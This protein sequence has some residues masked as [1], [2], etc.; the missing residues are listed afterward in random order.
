[1]ASDSGA[2][3]FVSK[4]V[5]LDA[6]LP[7]VRDLIGRRLLRGM[8]HQLQQRRREMT[9]QGPATG[10]PGGGHVARSPEVGADGSGSAR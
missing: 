1:M 4:R 9:L 5:I 8:H 2:D 10:V 7:A 6:L 3:A